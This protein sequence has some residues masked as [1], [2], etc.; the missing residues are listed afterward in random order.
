[1]KKLFL[2]LA[3]MLPM[4]VFA[5]Q[6]FDASVKVVGGIGVDDCKNKSFGAEAVFGYRFNEY[7]RLGVGTGISWCDLLFEE[8]SYGYDEYRESEAYVPLFVN[9]KAN[10]LKS[11]I[12]P[13]FSL[14]VG[15]S[16]LIPFSDYAEH[17]NL[18]AMVNPAFGVDFPLSK[19]SLFAEIGYKYQSMSFDGYGEEWDMNH[20]QITL[21]IG[22]NF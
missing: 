18:G 12:S 4:L 14:N 22:Y 17:A 10:F 6:G 11:G 7:F 15:Y 21:G 2:M 20:S 5:Q 3:M 9:G 8:E 1:M 13:Y 16:F 19:G